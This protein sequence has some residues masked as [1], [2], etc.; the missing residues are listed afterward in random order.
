MRISHQSAHLDTLNANR[1]R[2]RRVDDRKDGINHTKAFIQPP[3]TDIQIQE[4]ENMLKNLNFANFIMTK[5][6]KDYA[7]WFKDYARWCK[8]GLLYNEQS[9]KF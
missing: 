9:S 5:T 3:V 8:V 2:V 6:C 7:R 1:K 4:R